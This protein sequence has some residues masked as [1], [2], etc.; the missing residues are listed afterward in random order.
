MVSALPRSDLIL[1]SCSIPPG[2]LDSLPVSPYP[3][4]GGARIR[5]HFVRHKKPDDF[6]WT[7]WIG[8]TW[9]KWHEGTIIGYRDFAGRE[10]EV[11][12]TLIEL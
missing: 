5:A 12:Y 3:A 10:T 7:P 6:G 9:G 1:L 8:D 4:H 11:S 2:R